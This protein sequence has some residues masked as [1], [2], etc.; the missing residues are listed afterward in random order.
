MSNDLKYQKDELY[1]Y[2]NGLVPKISDFRIRSSVENWYNG[3]WIFETTRVWLIC[4]TQ[5]VRPG[6]AIA[7]LENS[8]NILEGDVFL[9]LFKITRKA[10]TSEIHISGIACE[11][12]KFLIFN[13]IGFIYRP[14]FKFELHAHSNQFKTCLFCFKI[15]LTITSAKNYLLPSEVCEFETKLFRM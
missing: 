7:R 3:K 11:M 14:D 9:K 15:T 5:Q 13:N 8:T 12:K 4:C 1:F 10:L 2:Q 6:S